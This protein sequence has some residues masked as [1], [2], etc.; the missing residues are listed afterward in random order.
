MKERLMSVRKAAQQFR[1][2]ERT[3]RQAVWRGDLP[4]YKPGKRTV[5]VDE[6]EVE[7]WIRDRRVRPWSPRR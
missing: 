7:D 2:S 3:I 5:Y 6:S 4:G 1:L